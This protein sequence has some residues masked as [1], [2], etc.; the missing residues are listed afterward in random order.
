MGYSIKGNDITKL[1]DVSY[2]SD[3]RTKATFNTSNYLFNW[4]NRQAGYPNA[5]FLTY[6]SGYLYSAEAFGGH[7]LKAGS[8]FT[9]A[10]KGHRPGTKRRWST[11]SPG[12][13]YINVFSDGE[14]WVSTTK[15]S[16]TG[17]KISTTD[18]AMKYVFMTLGGAGGGGGGSTLVASAGGGGGCGYIYMCVDLTPNMGDGLKVN[19]G[20]GGSG[21]GG[22]DNGSSGGATQLI[23]I[24]GQYYAYANGG[25]YGYG[26]GN[27]SGGGGSGGSAGLSFTDSG[28]NANY[29]VIKTQSGGS[30]GQRNNGG[31]GSYVSFTNYSPE[32]QTISYL[33]GSGG[34]GGGGSGGGGGGAS[35]LGNGASASSGS[36]G[37]TGGLGSGGSGA[38]YKAFNE[39]SGG[40]G[41]NG[42]CCID[43]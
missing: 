37:S 13:Y 20:S 5:Q 25:G 6:A 34:S 35:P 21:G 10:A 12:T 16:R 28:T 1:A 24:D 7:F 4:S 41:G 30:G 19:V 3:T 11:S 14:V 9:A 31:G 36:A 15:D 27:S 23:W 2:A 17:T 33:T 26:G 32:A 8:A 18:E 22:T 39:L 43:Y 29:R 40:S 38:S 42:F